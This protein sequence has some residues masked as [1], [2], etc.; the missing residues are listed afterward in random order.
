[1]D[2]RVKSVL[3]HSS[4]RFSVSIVL[5]SL[6]AFGNFW[7]SCFIFLGIRCIEVSS[8]SSITFSETSWNMLDAFCCNI[9]LLAIPGHVNTQISFFMWSV[10]LVINLDRFPSLLPLFWYSSWS[11]KDVQDLSGRF[12]IDLATYLMAHSSGDLIGSS[13]LVDCISFG[14]SN[15]C[16]HLSWYL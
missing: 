5:Y 15:S 1:M 3:L 13:R 7:M 6:L 16:K 11:S 8:P 4:K 10:S 14:F 9:R 2:K 12:L